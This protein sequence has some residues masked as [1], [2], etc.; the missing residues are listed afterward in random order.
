MPTEERKLQT[1]AHF[2][3]E[4]ATLM[5]GRVSEEAFFG[6]ENV[7]TGA[8]N[9]MKRATQLARSMV[10]EFGMSDRLGPQTYGRREEMPFL[11]KEYTEHRNYSE[12]VAKIIDEEVTKLI[13][14]GHDKAELVVKSHK[15]VITEIAD[16]LL[17]KETIDDKEFLKYFE[18]KK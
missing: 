2:L 13:A 17:K 4:I 8:Q 1:K 9:D 3:D 10:T 15:K 7:T 14:D 12:D 16:D 18:N 5:G 11:G 6:K